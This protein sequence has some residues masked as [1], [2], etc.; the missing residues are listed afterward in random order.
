MI[1]VIGRGAP[2]VVKQT[3]CCNCG[4]VLEYTPNEIKERNREDYSGGADGCTYIKCP[5][6]SQPVVLTS[7]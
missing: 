4:A 7:W 6:C 5:D 3:I 1:R 2:E